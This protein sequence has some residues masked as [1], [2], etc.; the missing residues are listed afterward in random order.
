MTSPRQMFTLACPMNSSDNSTDKSKDRNPLFPIGFIVLGMLTI[1]IW[2]YSTSPEGPVKE[3]DVVFST[4]RHYV[5]F[6]E[7]SRFQQ[8]GYKTFCILQPRGQLIVLQPSSHRADGTLTAKVLGETK[9]DFPFCPSQAEVIL[10]SHQ[11]SLKIDIWG[12]FKDTL[13][14]LFPTN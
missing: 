6:I 13:T 3:G 4:G 1:P 14:G 10:K 2:L 9:N 8:F 7:P 5:Y 12:G 11:A